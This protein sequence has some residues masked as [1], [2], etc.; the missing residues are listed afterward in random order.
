MVHL[1]EYSAI[2][3]VV[4]ICIV[5]YDSHSPCEAMEPLKRG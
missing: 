2:T 1:L 5:Q 3:E 4:Y